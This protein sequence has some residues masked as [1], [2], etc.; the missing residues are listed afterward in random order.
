MNALCADPSDIEA[1]LVGAVNFLKNGIKIPDGSFPTLQTPSTSR[2]AAGLNWL[3]RVA[4]LINFTGEQRRQAVIQATEEAQKATEVISSA[5]AEEAVRVPDAAFKNLEEQRKA[6]AD[7]TV[8]N[9]SISLTMGGYT[10]KQPPNGQ[11]LKQSYPKTR[12]EGSFSLLSAWAGA[13]DANEV[14]LLIWVTDRGNAIKPSVSINTILGKEEDEPLTQEEQA[15][16]DALTK[17]SSAINAANA[18]TPAQSSATK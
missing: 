13:R 9:I 16:E 17:L 11:T 10:Y 15:L 2:P 3:D 4:K 7:D 1:V 8:T 12:P 18:P 6:T 5:S 14:N